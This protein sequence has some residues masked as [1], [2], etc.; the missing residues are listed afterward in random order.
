MKNYNTTPAK[1]EETANYGKS[2]AWLAEKG[3]K[4]VNA[5]FFYNESP[6]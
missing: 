5:S 2:N 3:R 1:T 4:N 6:W